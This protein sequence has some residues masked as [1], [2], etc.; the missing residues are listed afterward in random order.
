MTGNG[1][2]RCSPRLSSAP[3]RRPVCPCARDSGLEDIAHPNYPAAA[4]PLAANNPWNAPADWFAL[5]LALK[6]KALLR[7][8]AVVAHWF[9]TLG[10][11]IHTG[12]LRSKAARG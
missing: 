10:S 2:D 6:S 4:R 9:P 12:R 8:L 1:Q 11:R 5:R 3:K 7:E